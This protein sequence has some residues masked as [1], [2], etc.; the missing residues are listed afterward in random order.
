M[1]LFPHMV[2]REEN[3][4]SLQENSNKNIPAMPNIFTLC[5]KPILN[6]TKMQYF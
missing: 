4:F 3:R 6:Y 1:T 5:Q 2:L